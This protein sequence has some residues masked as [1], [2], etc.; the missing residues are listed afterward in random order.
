MLS[1][2]QDAG[3]D[4]RIGVYVCHCGLNIAGVVDVEAVRE[5]ARFLE[6]VVVVRDNRYTCSE[7]GQKGIADDI[8]EF[9]LNRVV[10]ASC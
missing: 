8:K 10:I 6:G 9:M 3:F 7:V 4:A 5:S 2:L 1:M